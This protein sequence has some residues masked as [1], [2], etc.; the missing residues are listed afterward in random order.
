MAIS[1]GVE[2]R[3]AGRRAR[4]NQ[5][6]AQADFEEDEYSRWYD[7]RTPARLTANVAGSVGTSRAATVEHAAS[8][9]LG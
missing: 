6:D 1:G 4:D 8:L 2:L 7:G 5:L 9:G 3:S